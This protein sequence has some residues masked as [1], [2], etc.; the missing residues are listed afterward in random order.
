MN[1][2]PN[3]QPNTRQ[4]LYDP[5]LS[6]QLEAFPLPFYRLFS[7]HVVINISFG[8]NSCLWLC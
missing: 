4:A 8:S 3:M 1:H 2:R 7:T 5:D 6:A